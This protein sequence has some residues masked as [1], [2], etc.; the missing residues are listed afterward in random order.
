M[1]DD[2][3]PGALH[4]WRVGEVSLLPTFGHSPGHVAVLVASGGQQA[5]ITG[6]AAHHP[7]QLLAPEL[8]TVADFEPGGAVSSRL[9]LI[10]R[11]IDTGALLFGTH[12]ADPCAVRL[13][14]HSSDVALRPV[15]PTAAAL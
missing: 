8:A 5:I 9:S 2:G 11:A 3:T 4:N 13:E 1:S 10:D 14:G 6:D 15:E 12:F 7:I